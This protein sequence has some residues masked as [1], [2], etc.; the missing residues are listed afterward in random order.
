MRLENFTNPLQVLS[1]REQ[2]QE[3]TTL[4][5]RFLGVQTGF[6]DLVKG[7][8]SG[9]KSLGSFIAST[10]RVE[11]HSYAQAKRHIGNSAMNTAMGIASLTIGFFNPRTLVKEHQDRGLFRP[12]TDSHLNEET[13]FMLGGEYY[14]KQLES[15]V[16]TSDWAQNVIHIYNSGD[17][18]K[19]TSLYSITTNPFEDVEELE[20][21]LINAGLYHF[22]TL[23]ADEVDRIQW[24][25]AN[26]HKTDLRF[27]VGAYI[28]ETF[29]RCRQLV[30]QKSE[31]PIREEKTSSAP[32]QEERT[33]REILVNKIQEET[34][35]KNTT[36]VD[37]YTSV[38]E[39]IYE[40][41]WERDS[42]LVREI[43]DQKD[44][45]RE[46]VEDPEQTVHPLK[47]MIK[48]RHPLK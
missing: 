5:D 24:E 12:E 41:N 15:L 39:A 3:Q 34:W 6:V 27:T 1:E 29:E 10:F 20:E 11:G 48:E 33:D 9:G 13:S 19:S 14:S 38:Y 8:A 31:G 36:A 32:S 17:V 25:V 16:D 45:F 26:Q 18:Q 30:S 46:A 7:L 42:D 4:K 47:E 2:G 43:L 23:N 28:D 22:P 35:M 40:V 21:I 37:L 44:L